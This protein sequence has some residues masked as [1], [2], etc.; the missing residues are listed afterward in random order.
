MGFIRSPRRPGEVGRAH[1][2]AGS[3]CSA[4][5]TREL[6]GRPE[7]SAAPCSRAPVRRRPTHPNLCPPKPC[8]HFGRDP[9]AR[10]TPADEHVPVGTHRSP[11]PRGSHPGLGNACPERR[12]SSPSTRKSA[13]SRAAGCWH[14]LI[15]KRDDLPDSLQTGSAPLEHGEHVGRPR[16][17]APR[18]M[19][20]L[21]PWHGRLGAPQDEPGGCT[22][23]HSI[24]HRTRAPSA[25]R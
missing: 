13:M 11:S 23:L 19:P 3:L 2:T 12:L 15:S 6:T 18:T 25:A 8:A 14:R 7:K 17:L 16:R 1:S 5:R 21:A 22:R 9:R 4:G 10:P 24:G 20:S